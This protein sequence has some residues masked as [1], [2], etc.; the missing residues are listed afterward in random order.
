LI[1]PFSCFCD[2]RIRPSVPTM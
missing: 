2:W 1:W